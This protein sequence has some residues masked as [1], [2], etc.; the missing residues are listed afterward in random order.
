[1]GVKQI[2]ALIFNP[3]VITGALDDFFSHC[4]S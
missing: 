2:S 1:M 3:P 4:S